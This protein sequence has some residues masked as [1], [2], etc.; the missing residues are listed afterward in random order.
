MGAQQKSR[1][2]GADSC[3]QTHQGVSALTE[4]GLS[5]VVIQGAMLAV[6]RRR[7]RS[8]TKA[9]S[10]PRLSAAPV[11][12][13]TQQVAFMTLSAFFDYHSS[14][15]SETGKVTLTASLRALF[16]DPPW[17]TNPVLSRSQ[18]LPWHL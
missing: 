1:I 6:Q 18:V 11:R 9:V 7:P 13:C 14:K 17:A 12:P 15:T 8:G 5:V 2:L 16:R 10:I 4:H 3:R